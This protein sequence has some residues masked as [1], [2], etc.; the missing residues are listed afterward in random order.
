MARLYDAVRAS[1]GHKDSS[2][3]LSKQGYV[4]D[5]ALSSHNQSVFYSPREKKVI[6]SVAGTHNLRDI[7][8]DFY[9]A[10]GGLK[11]T[12]RYK[13]AQ[14]VLNKTR[15]KYNGSQ[16]TITGHSLGGTIAGYIA[17]KGRDD[18]VL[19]L[20]KGATIGQR[21]RGLEKS[22]RTSGD[23]VSAL[24]SNAKHSITLANKNIKT[25]I[26]PIDA[27]RAHNVSN[28]KTAPIFV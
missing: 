22:Y 23:A 16:M 20:D 24:S 19:T 2:K 6:Y 26:L 18:K 14:N 12:N 28:I 4:R 25:G 8:T 7:G 13:D 1:Y 27:L 5:N 21:T 3:N 15:E 9:L 17:S 10:L 11:Q